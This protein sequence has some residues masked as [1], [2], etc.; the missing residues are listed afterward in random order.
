M[1]T[2]LPC[3]LFATPRCCDGCCRNCQRIFLRSQSHMASTPTARQSRSRR[4]SSARHLPSCW[5]R[6]AHLSTIPRRE[7]CSS[8]ACTPPDQ[9]HATLAAHPTRCRCR[10]RSQLGPLI[11]NRTSSYLRRCPQPCR[12]MAPSASSRRHR[13]IPV[14]LIAQVA[15]RLP[16]TCSSRATSSFQGP[17]AAPGCGAFSPSRWACLSLRV[18]SSEPRCA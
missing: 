5:P 9:V 13:S 2:H 10:R 11:W 1:A 8:G 12:R 6:C 4:S 7:I 16:E 3:P 18:R 14:R 15:M 17:V